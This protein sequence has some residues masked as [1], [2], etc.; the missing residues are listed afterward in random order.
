MGA[1]AW[2]WLQAAHPTAPHVLRRVA[3]VTPSPSRA[4]SQAAHSIQNART[5][6][7][8]SPSGDG[9]AAPEDAPALAIDLSTDSATCPG[10]GAGVAGTGNATPTRTGAAAAGELTA[11]SPALPAESPPLGGAV[12]M[13]DDALAAAQ[14]QAA[15]AA[16]AAAAAEQTSLAV[17][18]P[19]VDTEKGVEMETELIDE[20]TTSADAHEVRPP[21]PGAR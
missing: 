19:E 6:S 14:A 21:P 13:S 1:A 5:A 2:K 15:D 3:Q 16:A 8:P 10:G 20:P 12:V 7:A 17:G 4:T 18:A 11:P 9:S